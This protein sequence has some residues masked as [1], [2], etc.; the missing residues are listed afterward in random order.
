MILP[1]KFRIFIRTTALNP[2]NMFERVI[3]RLIIASFVRISYKHIFD[4]SPAI[5][6]K[7]C[8]WTVSIRSRCS[9]LLR[10]LF[11]LVFSVAFHILAYSSFEIWITRAQSWDW[12]W[13]H[14]RSALL[15]MKLVLEDLFCILGTLG[16]L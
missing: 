4:L 8:L 12:C 10:I 13:V 11:I 7:S 9:L 1:S 16:C 3:L 5:R 2:W 15:D 14:I 6:L